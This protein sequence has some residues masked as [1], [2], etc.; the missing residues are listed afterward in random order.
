MK[1]LAI[2]GSNGFLGRQI[3]KY[4]ENKYHVIKINGDDYSTIDYDNRISNT[5]NL[6]KAIDNLNNISE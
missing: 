4:F 1:V 3:C 2:N 5:V 6:A